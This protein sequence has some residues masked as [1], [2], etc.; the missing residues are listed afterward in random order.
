MESEKIRDMGGVGDMMVSV[1]IRGA[2]D[3]VV[4]VIIRR[5]SGGE[6]MKTKLKMTV[7]V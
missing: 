6:D 1:I 2:A 5:A 4:R 7:R 3:M